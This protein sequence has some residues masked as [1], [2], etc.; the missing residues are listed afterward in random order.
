MNQ[1]ETGI[2]LGGILSGIPSS[3]YGH[4]YRTGYGVKYAENTSVVN[5]AS[6]Y[7]A[8]MQVETS[9]NPYQSG[10]SI[11]TQIDELAENKMDYIYKSSNWVVFVDPKVDLSFFKEQEDDDQELMIIHY[12][13]QY[14]SA[15]G[16]DDIT[17]TQKSEQ[18]EEIIQE[19]LKQK[20]VIASKPD[21]HNIISLFNAI[22]GGWMLRLISAKKLAGAVDSNFSREKMSIL[23]AVK[24]CM[25][26]YSHKDIIWVPISLEEMLRVSGGA[27]YSQRDGL[28]SAT[29]VCSS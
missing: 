15:S 13:D 28:L 22:N 1:I 24:L 12:S 20:G 14:T 7:N 6:L 9:G 11:S 27:G 19:Q 29:M 10:T 3:K 25:A 17:V 2:S 8:L 5:F 18:Y 21:V 26:Y 4:K 23:S 16:Y